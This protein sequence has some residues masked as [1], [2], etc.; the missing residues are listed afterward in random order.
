MFIGSGAECVRHIQDVPSL[1][2]SLAGEV[3]LSEQ[4]RSTIVLTK[5]PGC[6]PPTVNLLQVLMEVSGREQTKLLNQF[7][8]SS[9]VFQLSKNG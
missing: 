2:C 9:H 4:A 8:P 6:F 5:V 7:L 3:V 1:A